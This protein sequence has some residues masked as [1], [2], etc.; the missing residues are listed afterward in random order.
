MWV[1]T[2]CLR[3]GQLHKHLKEVRGRARSRARAANDS[4]IC[5]L[6]VIRRILKEETGS[7]E[8]GEEA[9]EIQVTHR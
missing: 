6:A 9:V 8:T 4:Q 3:W 5:R 1:T 7:K 2:V